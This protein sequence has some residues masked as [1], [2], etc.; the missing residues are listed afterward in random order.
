MTPGE[1]KVLASMEA[2]RGLIEEALEE[3]RNERIRQK[4]L[5]ARTRREQQE[6]KPEPPAIKKDE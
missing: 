5:D 2:A 3:W 1:I 6:T 4:F